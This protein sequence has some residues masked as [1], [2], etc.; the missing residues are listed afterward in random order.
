M[1][2]KS[3]VDSNILFI[4]LIFFS[5]I[6][7]IIKSVTI[8]ILTRPKFLK[9]SIFRYFLAS[10]LV[11]L[12]SLIL[13]WFHNIPFFINLDVPL[14]FCRLHEI[15]IFTLYDFYPW[16]NVLNSID[17]LLSFK[18]PEKFRF[19]KQCKYQVLAISLFF[20][21]ASLIN[22][23]RALYVNF[24]NFTMC[25]LNDYQIGFYMSLVNAFVSVIIPFFIMLL[26]TC[27]IF[28]YLITQKRR[29]QQNFRN[30]NRQKNFIKCVLTIDIFLLFCYI[31]FSCTILYQYMFE[32]SPIF[33]QNL[34]II[35][36]NVSEFLLFLQ[37]FCNF[38]VYFLCN[39]LFKH[40]FLSMISCFR[41][42][43]QIRPVTI[44]VLS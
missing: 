1:E 3:I 9:E 16:I 12:T 29:L 34:N 44:N 17:R 33:D 19:I 11:E 14:I 4:L 10:E 25:V 18:Y 40:H 2:F 39:K 38:F 21:S 43:P 24:S 30:Y 15:L 32:N 23:P 20:L 8:H 41:K 6:I 35:F 27:L 28:H 31:T 7:V 22:V 37:V 42:S 26:S 5:V 13:I 36:S